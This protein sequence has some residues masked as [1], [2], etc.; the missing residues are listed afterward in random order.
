MDV[1]G[2]GDNLINPWTP[3]VNRGLFKLD[4]GSVMVWVVCSWR[5][6]GSLIRLDTLTGGVGTSGS[7]RCHLHEDQAQDALDRPVVKKTATSLEMHAYSQ[8]LHRLPSR[9]RRLRLE[10]CRSR[11]NWTAAECNQVVLSDESRFNPSSDDNCVRVWRPVVN[12]SILLLQRYPTPTARV[13][14]WGVIAYNT[15]SPLILI[16]GTMSAQMKLDGWELEYWI[17]R[18]YSCQEKAHHFGVGFIVNKRL[19]NTVIDFQAISMRLCKIRLRG[20]HY[21]TTLICAHAPTDDKDK[22]EKD[23]FYNLLMKSYN[24]CPAQDIKLVIG[25]FNAKIGR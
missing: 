12:A 23:L 1:Y 24:S 22:T 5:D 18:L 11:G 17:K 9:H 3:H 13:M 20:K 16:R 25:D 8:L 7:E 2:Y 21:N 19:R 15:R 6:M 14:V 4:G 10:W